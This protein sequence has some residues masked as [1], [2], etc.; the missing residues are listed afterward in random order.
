MM[1]LVGDIVKHF[2]FDD[3][4]IDSWTFKLFYKGCF[5][6][7]LMGSMVGILRQV[8]HVQQT[9]WIQNDFSCTIL[10]YSVLDM[11]IFSYYLHS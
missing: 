5:I 9:Q 2:M 7:H 6:F 8:A 3:V 4:N 1:H 11:Y 10:N